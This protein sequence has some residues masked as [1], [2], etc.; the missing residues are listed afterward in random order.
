M[1]G[2]E[3]VVRARVRSALRLCRPTSRWLAD[4]PLSRGAIGRPASRCRC[5]A[6]AN[7]CSLRLTLLQRHPPPSHQLRHGASACGHDAGGRWHVLALQDGAAQGLWICSIMTAGR[8]A[9]SLALY[10]LSSSWVHDCRLMRMLQRQCRGHTAATRLVL[11]KPKPPACGDPFTRDRRPPPLPNPAA[12]SQLL[13][14]S[15]I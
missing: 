11:G 9:H 6:A 15:D 2:P 8:G 10:P 13:R 14:F 12:S 5:V 7:P 1:R 3:H 4:S